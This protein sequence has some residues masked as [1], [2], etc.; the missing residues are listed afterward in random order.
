MKLSCGYS[1]LEGME[2]KNNKGFW[3]IVVIAFL[4][5]CV[6]HPF[7][8]DRIPMHYDIQGNIDRWGS[9]NENFI[10]PILLLLFSFSG[11]V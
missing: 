3:S 7:L 5:T 11:R 2:M 9:K 1:S 10:F 8:P 4:A 6:A